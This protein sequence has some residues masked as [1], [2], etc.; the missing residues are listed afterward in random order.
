MFAFHKKEDITINRRCGYDLFF[1]L[2]VLFLLVIAHLIIALDTLG[3]PVH[4]LQD[5]LFQRF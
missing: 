2:L 4:L 5:L 1:C 3:Y